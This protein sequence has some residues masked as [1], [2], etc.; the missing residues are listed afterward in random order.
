[1]EKVI[2]L[3]LGKVSYLFAVIFQIFVDFAS[4]FLS[5]VCD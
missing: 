3:E 4:V 2:S 1:M 5:V